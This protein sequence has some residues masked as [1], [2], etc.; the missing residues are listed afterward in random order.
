MTIDLCTVD[1]TVLLDSSIHITHSLTPML[2]HSHAHKLTC[3]FDRLFA[4]SF[5]H[6]QM[7]FAHSFSHEQ[8]AFCVQNM[9][10][11][12]IHQTGFY[13]PSLQVINLPCTHLASAGTYAYCISIL[14]SLLLVLQVIGYHGDFL[15]KV[16]KGCLLSRK[17]TLLQSL[18]QLKKQVSPSCAPC[19]PVTIISIQVV[20]VFGEMKVQGVG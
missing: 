15:R 19:S 2:T 10:Q 5:S 4:H 8:M 20:S 1:L 7:A 11:V 14:P 12:F 16:L 3:W 17:L 6:E 13:Q 9:L 18:V